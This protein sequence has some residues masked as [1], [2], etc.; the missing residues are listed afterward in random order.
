MGMRVALNETLRHVSQF[1]YGKLKPGIARVNKLQCVVLGLL[2]KMGV[3]FEKLWRCF[4][5]IA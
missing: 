2:M 5:D 4:D 3:L 1:N